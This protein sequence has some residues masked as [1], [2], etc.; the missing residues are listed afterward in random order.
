MT[1]SRHLILALTVAGGAAAAAVIAIR[2]RERRLKAARH[3]MDLQ[4]WENECG[5]PAPDAVVK[6]PA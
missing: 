2:R 4:R 1:S 5:S 3:E 6:P